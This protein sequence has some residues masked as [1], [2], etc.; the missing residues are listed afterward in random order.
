MNYNP[1]H[2]LHHHHHQYSSS[3]SLCQILHHPP[4]FQC[5]H[6]IYT[7]V[8]LIFVSSHNR[9]TKTAHAL[10]ADTRSFSLLSFPTQVARTAAKLLSA[11]FVTRSVATF[12]YFC[13]FRAKC[14]A[15]TTLLCAIEP[16][17]HTCMHRIRIMITV[18]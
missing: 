7:G 15:C 6:N 18:Q 17:H 1:R 4:G 13:A 11:F 14:L 8:Q 10:A 2:R 3:S 9:H 5:E 12:T 16:G